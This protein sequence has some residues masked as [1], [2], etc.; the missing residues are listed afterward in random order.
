MMKKKPAI[1]KISDLQDKLEAYRASALAAGKG[2]ARTG[3]L[4]FASAAAGGAALAMAPAAE[5]AIQYSGLRNILVTLRTEGIDLDNDGFTD[6]NIIQSFSSATVSSIL[7]TN[8]KA[9]IDPQKYGT[10]NI[11][12]NAI[13]VP[14]GANRVKALSNDY[15]IVNDTATL[16]AGTGTWKYSQKLLDN[17]AGAVDKYIGVRFT[18]AGGEH[19]GWVQ[20]NV[21]ADRS[22]ITIVDW[23]YEDTP[24]ASILAG[25]GSGPKQVI[26]TLNEWGIIVLMTLL[27][28]AAAWKMNKPE[29]LRA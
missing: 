5:A 19:F 13:A 8:E 10:A 12:A 22:S 27:A 11:V 29:L 17:F 2:P 20:V 28:G 21:A 26:P 16:L 25:A 3:N 9:I 24:G 1:K 14:G 23:A 18:N 4:A 15:N 7:Y 6:L